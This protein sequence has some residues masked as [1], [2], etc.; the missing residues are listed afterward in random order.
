VSDPRAVLLPSTAASA[1][2]ARV[3]VTD[4]LAGAGVSPAAI[5]DAGLVVS[6]LVSN[7]IRH[8]RPLPGATV[9]LTWALGNGSVEISVR[10]GG[11]STPPR[12]ALPSLS[13]LGGRGLAVVER[14]ACRWGI[15]T[16]EAGTV[17]WAVLPAPRAAASATGTG[18]LS[19]RFEGADQAGKG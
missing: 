4:G 2:A 7:A 10:D 8:A 16:G 6:E 3:N 15:S 5:S 14:L 12:P 1:A 13:S 9:Q 18:P 17:V 11:A 19:G